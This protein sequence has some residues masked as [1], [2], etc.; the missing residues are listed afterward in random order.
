M[1]AVSRMRGSGNK[2]GIGFSGEAE[3]FRGVGVH[4]F[5]Q[6]VAGRSCE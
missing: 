4:G 1:L 6:V 3:G 5:N 2:G